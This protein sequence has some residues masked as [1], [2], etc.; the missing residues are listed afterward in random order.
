MYNVIQMNCSG[1]TPPTTLVRAFGF[2]H[3]FLFPPHYSYPSQVA[4]GGVR[5]Q[6]PEDTTN[7]GMHFLLRMLYSQLRQ[8]RHR[9]SLFWASVQTLEVV[10][11]HIMNL[12]E[13]FARKYNLSE[14]ERALT[15]FHMLTRCSG[16]TTATSP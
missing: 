11:G 5:E 13:V 15:I 6:H 7:T 16:L 1:D 8:E 10:V 14:E 3:H 2:A 12:A 4:V 9:R